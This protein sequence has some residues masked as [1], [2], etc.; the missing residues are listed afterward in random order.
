M[1]E[2]WKNQY[3]LKFHN[4]I[5][6]FFQQK[7]RQGNTEKRIDHL[8]ICAERVPTM[9][10]LHTK[11]VLLHLRVL[12]ELNSQY[13]TYIFPDIGNWRQIHLKVRKCAAL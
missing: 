13:F 8:R 10:N 9:E 3:A 2:A 7:M 4:E 11:I 6:F 12:Y 1:R 5:R